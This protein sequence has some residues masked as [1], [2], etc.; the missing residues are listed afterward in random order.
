MIHWSPAIG[1]EAGAL[2]GMGRP[3]VF[4]SPL[5]DL[6]AAGHETLTLDPALLP[7][8]RYCAPLPEFGI[9]GVDMPA[10]YNDHEF[11]RYLPGAWPL[12]LDGGGGFYCLDLRTVLAGSRT[13]ESTAPLVWSHAGNLGWGLQDHVR[14][15]TN[16]SEFLRNAGMSDG[17]RGRAAGS[18]P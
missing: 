12:A 7:V 15:S 14:I 6:S 11:P 3:L 17:L 4:P 16:A 5:I 8:S 9:L 1:A 10:Y 2:L 13:D 18:A